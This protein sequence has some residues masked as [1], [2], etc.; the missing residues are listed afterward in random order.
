MFVP[1]F[2]R[3]YRNIHTGRRGCVESLM[4]LLGVLLVGS[5]GFADPPKKDPP[6]SPQVVKLPA[7]AERVAVGGTGRMILL[8]LPKVKLIA[9]FDV[10]EGKLVKYLPAPDDDIVLT[11]GRDHLFV[12]TSETCTM[13]RWSLTTLQK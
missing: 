5:A 4:A 6:D 9:V 11:A 2:G 8:H 3:V 1:V 7:R 10:K 12:V 13:Q